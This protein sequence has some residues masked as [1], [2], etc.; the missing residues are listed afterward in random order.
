M[1]RLLGISVVLLL[2]FCGQASSEDGISD[3]EILLVLHDS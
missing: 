3:S 1:K 2:T